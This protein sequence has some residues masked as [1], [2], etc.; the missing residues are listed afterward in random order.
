MNASARTALAV[1]FC[2]A[3]L[4]CESDEPRDPRDVGADVADASDAGGDAPEDAID[5]APDLASDTDVGADADTDPDAGD[6]A[7]D[8][9]VPDTNPDWFEP[10]AWCDGVAPDDTCFALARDAWSPSIDLAVEIADTFM[11]EHTPDSL[12]WNWTDAVMLVGIS[13]L[14]RVTDDPVYYRYIGAYLDHHAAEGY[15]IHTS[16]TSAPAAL[17]VEMISAGYDSPAYQQIVSDALEYY[18]TAAKR[19][20]EGGISHFGDL[21]LFEAELWADSLFMFGNVMTGWGEWTGGTEWLEEYAHQVDVFATLMQE[22]SGFYRH[23][24]YSI[25]QQ[26]DDLYWARANGWILAALYDHASVRMDDGMVP[27]VV[28]DS[29]ERLADAVVASQDEGGLWWTVL[30]R[31]GETYVETSAS[32]LFA[33]G[34]ARGWRYGLLDDEVLPVI[35]SAMQGV[36]D[37]VERGEGGRP[38]VNGISGPTNVGRFSDYANVPVQ[39]DIA[40]GLGA[41]LLALTETSGLPIDLSVSAP[42]LPGAVTDTTFS[43]AVETRRAAFYDE[44]VSRNADAGGI[45]GQSCRVSAGLAL[46]TPPIDAAID[47]MEQRLDT[48]DFT[49][50]GL[51]RMLYLD[52]ETGGL[53][54]TYRQR[55]DDTMLGFKYWLDEPGDDEMAYWTENHQILFHVAEY[56]MGQRHP[57]E[58]FENSGM[59]G[60]EHMA[61]ARPRILRWM[62]MRGRW[63]FSE[64]HSPV[65]FNE[66]IPPLLNLYDFAD[67]EELRRGAAVVLDLIAIDLATNMYDT[68]F[69]TTAGRTNSG[70]FVAGSR[71][72]TREFAH[73]ALGNTPPRSFDNFSGAFM[74]TST[75]APPAILE[76]L[77]ERSADFFEHRQRDSWDVAE[78][79]RIGVSYQGLDDIVVW[80]GQSTLAHPAVFQG[81]MNELE[82]YD[83]FDGFLFGQLPSEVLALIRSLSGTPG[84][85][86][87]A[88]DL[89][90]L[91]VGLGLETI[92][93]YV[94]RTPDYQLAA[95]Q[96]WKPG[97]WSAQTLMFR[98]SLSELVSI[99]PTGPG[100]LGG[101]LVG[102]DTPTISE[103][104]GGWMP[105]ITAHRN[106]AVLQYDTEEWK[107][108]VGS[109]VG[110]SATRAYFPTE[111]M[112]EW[113]ARGQWLFGRVGDGYVGLWSSQTLRLAED[114]TDT[115]V[116]TEPE[117]VFV[118]EMGRAEDDGTFDAFADRLAAA[119]VSVVETAIG[120]D[121]SYASPTLGQVEVGWESELHVDGVVVHTGPYDRMDNEFVRQRRGRDWLDVRIDDTV[122]RLDFDAF[123]RTAYTLE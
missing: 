45:Y 56:L 110:R 67:D 118:V 116:G 74:A 58:V 32:A 92:D 112:D 20:P 55:L 91:S 36:V 11:A 69:A 59:T 47:K 8:A 98:A 12:A 123:E 26:D 50:N 95:A 13:Q 119:S 120:W 48:S 44:C 39:P 29:A 121:V 84:L 49:A 60:A 104:V 111:L 80:A 5:V 94:Y 109:V 52:D 77:A 76:T 115:W 86:N 78:G 54:D 10:P 1:S 72:S 73:I 57:D 93:T 30:N 65:Y 102:E 31:P 105:R 68:A 6:V 38:I 22:E 21:E 66:D 42:G 18:A 34:L 19:T 108:I 25:F 61:H 85:V 63:G 9:D 79:P 53:G 103:W 117:N 62:H 4:S 35:E 46:H 23:A 87:L 64:W 51:V 43:D 70:K 99:V 15:G 88:W 33:Y 16:D 107:P 101:D 71:D 3:T 14:A 2:L 97:Y 100:A 28:V 27:G 90:P 24:A 113:E 106:V 89:E 114:T 41:V 37:Q 75:Y 81:A 40:Y 122:L 17:A 7:V 82:E 83:L 96:N